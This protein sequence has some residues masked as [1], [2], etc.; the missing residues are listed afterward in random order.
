VPLS[1]ISLKN[2]RCFD[3][4]NFSLSSGINFFYGSN[5]SGKTSILEAVYI[6]S[7]GKS[8]KSSN[9]I[10]LINYDRDKFSAKGYDNKK[11]YIVDIEKNR[12]KP[13]SVVLNN[14][15]ITASK[16]LKE[17]PCTAIHNSTFSFADA[18]PDFRRKLLDRS[19]FTADESFSKCWFTYYRTL[20]QRNSLL[21]NNR[22]SDIYTWNQKLSIEG[23]KLN[24]YRTNFFNKTITEFKLLLD[25]IKP[26]DVFDFFDVID[27]NFFQGWETK[28]NL[29]DVLN[30]NLSSDLK[31]KTTTAGPHKADIKFLIK[32]IDARQVLSRGEQKFF[33]ILWSC[34]QHEVLKKQFKVH[35]T[36][37]VDDIKSELDDRVFNL[38]LNLLNHVDTQI[39]FSC[40]DDCFSSKIIN[41]FNNFKKF[42]V[43]HLRQL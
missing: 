18:S 27:I 43:E 20:K 26:K 30:N 19:I 23:D 37:L 31:R 41:S 11:G 10:S 7:S 34:A 1:K 29:N 21:K 36:L 13:I 25:L 4:I 12:N 15:K 42:H 33:S 14:K 22:I 16:L 9:L 35:A 8:F 39:I 24:N 38:F 3:E 17:F 32:K 2:F 40:I 6:F 5:G 28:K